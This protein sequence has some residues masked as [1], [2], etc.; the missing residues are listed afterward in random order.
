MRCWQQNTKVCFVI[1]QRLQAGLVGFNQG[2]W[3]TWCEQSDLNCCLIYGWKMELSL[4]TPRGRR[5]HRCAWQILS[6]SSPNLFSIFL[7]TPFKSEMIPSVQ[8]LEC[9]SKSVSI[10]ATDEPRNVVQQMWPL[11]KNSTADWFYLETA[12]IRGG[13]VQLGFNRQLSCPLRS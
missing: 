8:F 13:G 3:W 2:K 7:T 1:L 9:M 11:G 10:L 6:Q 5:L 12:E 4:Q